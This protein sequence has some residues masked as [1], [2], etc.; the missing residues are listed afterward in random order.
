MDG[1]V[2]VDSKE[3][4]GLVKAVGVVEVEVGGLGGAALG[5]GT[6]KWL[7]CYR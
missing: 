6:Q 1:L 2:S 3:L 5:G 4:F 7:G